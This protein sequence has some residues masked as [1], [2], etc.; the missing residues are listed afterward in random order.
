MAK[1]YEGK[2]GIGQI[3]FCIFAAATLFIPF[4]MD[5]EIIFTYKFLL[6]TEEYPFAS[7]IV[8]LSQLGFVNSVFSL[9]G[10]SEAVPEIVFQ[11]LPYTVYAFYAIVAFDLLFVILLLILRFEGFRKTL[12]AFSIL[13]GFVMLILMIVFLAS[14]VGFFTLYASGAYGEGA[15]IF[16]CIK[17]T[18]VIYFFGLFVFALIGMIKQF[19]SFFG[20]SY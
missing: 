1:D 19:S 18:G 9:A 14:V 6:P 15:E 5:P 3:I 2:I 12:R 8:T 17:N 11:I 16:A 13:F 7:N 10:I 20:K 4:V